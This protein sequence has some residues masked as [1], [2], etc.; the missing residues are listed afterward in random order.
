MS[1]KTRYENIVAYPEVFAAGR[2]DL[3]KKTFKIDSSIDV[4]EERSWTEAKDIGSSSVDG[5]IFRAPLVNEPSAMSIVNHEEGHLRWSPKSPRYHGVHER[6][7]QACEDARINTGNYNMGNRYEVGV[8]TKKVKQLFNRDLASGEYEALILRATAAISSD[9]DDW[10]REA[11]I[12]HPDMPE[13]WSIL[14]EEWLS[15]VP[16]TLLKH[17]IKAGNNH[18]A[19]FKT[20]VYLARKLKKLIGEL[21]KDENKPL[22]FKRGEEVTRKKHGTRIKSSIMTG[23]SRKTAEKIQET[24]EKLSATDEEFDELSEEVSSIMENAAKYEDRVAEGVK[25]THTTPSDR[26][27]VSSALQKAHVPH[28]YKKEE[29]KE[30]GTGTMEIL[31]PSLVIRQPQKK[32]LGL[33]GSSS[34]DEGL[35]FNRPDRLL[36]DQKVFKKKGK[37]HGGTFLVDVSG[38]MSL[39]EDEIEEI[40][41]LSGRDTTVATYCG[42]DT[43]GWL[44]VVADRGYRARRKD[45]KPKGWGNIV[46][47]PAMEWLCNAE[48][49]RIWVCDGLVTG[50]YD[51]PNPSLTIE[52]FR[53]GLESGVR[54]VR[55]VDHLLSELDGSEGNADLSKI[56]LDCKND[57]YGDID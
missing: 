33:R 56:G 23:I 19:P 57:P 47:L 32:L 48:G 13:E 24:A 36:L 18:V 53:K 45:L 44:T 2:N 17:R 20:T 12:G 7:I 49:P 37:R 21:D 16:A 15:F 4:D 9:I 29:F 54:I 43:R 3:S 1:K 41:L 51:N 22:P 11:L 31:Y 8:F 6:F 38:S 50:R 42:L 35:V 40:V 34:S 55:S 52:V 30:Y 14:I 27:R 25:K 26:K 46:D 10:M 28:I 39:T 5:M